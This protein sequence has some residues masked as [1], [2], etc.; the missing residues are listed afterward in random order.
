MS[1]QITPTGAN[2]AVARIDTAMV[3]GLSTMKNMVTNVEN[4][5]SSSVEDD[6][7]KVTQDQIITAG[8]ERYANLLA[9]ITAV[10]AA[11]NIIV[12]GTY[13]AA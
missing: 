12:P 4:V 2:K 5:F 6:G 9:S 13:P 1:T 7:T 11:V 8:G 10:K 3:N